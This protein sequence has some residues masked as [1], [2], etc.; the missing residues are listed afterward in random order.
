MHKFKATGQSEG[1]KY[2][3]TYYTCGACGAT[4]QVA[5]SLTAPVDN[6][7]A[8]VALASITSGYACK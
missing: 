2:R 5:S 4:E 1:R 8:Q 7:S 3:Y 6:A